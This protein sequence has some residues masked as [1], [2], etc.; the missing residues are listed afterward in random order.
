MNDQ[1]PS[2]SEQLYLPV[3]D[4]RRALERYA[5]RVPRGVFTR[6]PYGCCRVSSQLLARYLVTEWRVP[7]VHF[8]SGVRPQTHRQGAWESHLWIKVGECLI[9]VTADQYR[10]VDVPVIVTNDGSWHDTFVTQRRLAYSELMTMSPRE[11]ARM[12]RA[13]RAVRRRLGRVQR[14]RRG[15]REQP[16]VAP[17]VPRRR[18]PAVQAPS[19]GGA[20]PWLPTGRLAAVGSE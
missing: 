13:Y 11:T 17:E 4:F 6:F 2:F 7:P 10:E 12:E 14:V 19:L 1:S 18:E 5:L 3:Y 20:A 8:V 15:V 9:D 16:T